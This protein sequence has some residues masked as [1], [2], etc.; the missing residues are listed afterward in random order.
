MAPFGGCSLVR[1]A[2]LYANIAQSDTPDDLSLCFD[3]IT[4]QPAKLM[5]LGDHGIEVGNPADL[6]VL[7]CT[8][9]AMAV[10]EVSLPLLGIKRGR[11]SFVREAPRLYRPDREK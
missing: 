4:A 2:N 6:I 7:D 5:N 10:A 1:M 3:L 8:D 9:A 11:R